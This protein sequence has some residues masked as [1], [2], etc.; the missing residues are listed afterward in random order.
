[1]SAYVLWF[2]VGFVLLAAEL[3]TGTFYL[4]VLAVA[5]A[6]AGLTAL[7]GGSFALQLVVA[8][9]I[10]LAGSF[11]LRRRRGGRGTAPADNPVQHLD[12]GQTL[13]I[14]HWSVGRTAR[15][16]YR[17]AQW[18]VDLA[19]GED[20]APGEFVIREIQGSRLVVAARR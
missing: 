2:V 4:L 12:V 13:R 3:L 15:A 17:G 8:A 7:A 11:W 10:A 14:E 9:T 20:A 16:T 18:D 19:P 1:M 5:A 6:A